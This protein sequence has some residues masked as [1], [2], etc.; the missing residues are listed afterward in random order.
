METNNALQQQTQQIAGVIQQQADIA[1][2]AMVAQGKALIDSMAMQAMAQAQ[3]QAA[4]EL[5]I[6]AQQLLT[7]MAGNVSADLSS[8]EAMQPAEIAPAT[9]IDLQLVPIALPAAAQAALP[10]SQRMLNAAA[11][12]VSKAAKRRARRAAAEQTSQEDQG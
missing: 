1:A 5:V 2:A 3:A 6:H 9:V 10:A 8:L 4:G 11:P 12:V 7:A